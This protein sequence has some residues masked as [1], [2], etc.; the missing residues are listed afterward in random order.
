MSYPEMACAVVR[1]APSLNIRHGLFLVR[2]FWSDEG[3]C[4]YEMADGKASIQIENGAWR[5]SGGGDVS[6]DGTAAMEAS[7]CVLSLEFPDTSEVNPE[8][9]NQLMDLIVEH[10]AFGA[11]GYRPYE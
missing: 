8:A 4:V 9:L 11:D 7:P 1:I 10:G 2:S 5:L 6:S 3:T